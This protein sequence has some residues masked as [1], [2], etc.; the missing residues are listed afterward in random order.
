MKEAR[1][2][3]GG[4]GAVREQDAKSTRSHAQFVDNRGMRVQ[5]VRFAD[6]CARC[7]PHWPICVGGDLVG[8][9]RVA[10]TAKKRNNRTA[11]AT[12]GFAPRGGCSS[13]GR[14]L[15][16]GNL[17]E[18]RRLCAEPCGPAYR[19]IVEEDRIG[20]MLQMLGWQLPQYLAVAVPAKA[21]AGPAFH[22]SS[23]PQPQIGRRAALRQRDV[24][25]DRLRRHVDPTASR[26]TGLLKPLALA[27]IRR[28]ERGCRQSGHSAWA[29]NIWG[30]PRGGQ[31]NQQD[32]AEE[33]TKVFSKHVP[34]SEGNVPEI[35]PQYIPAHKRL[36]QG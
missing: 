2:R 26:L 30:R 27:E 4:C 36:T 25:P 8:W 22:L 20:W 6:P 14:H 18:R 15:G 1:E 17:A 12:A 23:A 19:P 35:E 31:R 9:Q 10:K 24:R 13:G 33:R 32:H 3:M 29:R 34:P 21:R 16:H 5:G 11:A 28:L 7:S